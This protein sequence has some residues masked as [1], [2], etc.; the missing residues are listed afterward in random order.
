M[1]VD[2]Y[3][4]PRSELDSAEPTPLNGAKLGAL[5]LGTPPTALGLLIGAVGIT[6]DIGA[7]KPEG[8]G[9]Y[10]GVMLFITLVAATGF[11]IGAWLGKRME[12]GGWWRGLGWS[13]LAGLAWGPSD[14]LM[15]LILAC[16]VSLFRGQ[17]LDR[18]RLLPLF[19]R[20]EWAAITLL[21]LVPA[22][23]CA[24]G[25]GLQLRHRRRTRR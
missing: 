8:W 1:S 9:T 24:L 22:L 19:N 6:S 25:L 17:P 21:G 16:G 23:P 14:F 3:Q 11:P 12:R 5:W 20:K 4:V 15:L 2:P 7:G 13:L 18:A 10:A